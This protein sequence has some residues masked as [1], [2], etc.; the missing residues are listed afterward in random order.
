MKTLVS[1]VNLCLITTYVVALILNVSVFL[2]HI[3]YFDNTSFFIILSILQVMI[4]FYNHNVLKNYG[5]YLVFTGVLIISH[6]ANVIIVYFKSQEILNSIYN[7]KGPQDM[8]GTVMAQ[9]AMTI[10]LFIFVA[11]AAAVIIECIISIIIRLVKYK[12]AKKNIK[13]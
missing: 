6:I 8:L 10:Y 1:K 12:R 5:A 9:A 7:Y 3:P 11:L 4:I 13:L 2:Y